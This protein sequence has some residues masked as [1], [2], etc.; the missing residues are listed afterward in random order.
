MI[1]QIQTKKKFNVHKFE[2]KGRTHKIEQMLINPSIF[3]L[4]TGFHLPIDPSTWDVKQVARVQKNLRQS[5]F[6]FLLEN[7][8]STNSYILNVDAPVRAAGKS[9]FISM[10]LTMPVIE[11]GVLEA[12]EAFC[13]DWI[14]RLYAELNFEYDGE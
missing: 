5:L 2:Y 3:T 13:W 1:K 8:L 6:S 4:S 14:D 10:I 7:D 9:V 11:N 12:N